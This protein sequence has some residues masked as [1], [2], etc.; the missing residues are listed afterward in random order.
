MRIMKNNYLRSMLLFS[1]ILVGLFAVVG[2]SPE[3][4]RADGYLQMEAPSTG[5][6]GAGKTVPITIY[7]NQFFIEYMR[8]H[9]LEFV[10]VRLMVLTQAQ[11]DAGVSSTK[12]IEGIT[13][14]GWDMSQ[15][16][17]AFSQTINWSTGGTVADTA[18]TNHYIVF[19]A[20]NLNPDNSSTI[21]PTIAQAQDIAIKL[22]GTGGGGSGSGTVGSGGSGGGAPYAPG[23]LSLKYNK[24]TDFPSLFRLIINLLQTA[25]WVGALIGFVYGGAT[26]MEAA[27]DPNKVAIGKKFI[28]YSL[29]GLLLAIF[30]GVIINAVIDKFVNFVKPI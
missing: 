12:S 17:S 18:N 15:D 28:W 22:S 19:K 24:V 9:E 27:A 8:F 26:L 14:I 20:Y 7:F 3:K 6:V 29:V 10:F 5:E 13:K 4:A 1:A 11:Y 2:F 25:V 21:S 16:E 30:T 23:I